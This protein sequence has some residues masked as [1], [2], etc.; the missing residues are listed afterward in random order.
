MR[1]LPAAKEH[2]NAEH[3]NANKQMELKVKTIFNT[4]VERYL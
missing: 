4:L 1:E 3:M 2:L